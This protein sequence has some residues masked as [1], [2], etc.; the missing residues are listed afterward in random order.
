M[1]DLFEVKRQLVREAEAV[2]CIPEGCMSCVHDPA[3]S[4]RLIL[5]FGLALAIN[6]YDDGLVIQEEHCIS[7]LPDHRRDLLAG[8]HFP[9]VISPHFF[10]QFHLAESSMGG[11][12]DIDAGIH[13]ALQDVQKLAE[14]FCRVGIAF[15]VTSALEAVPA[16]LFAEIIDLHLLCP[17]CGIND[18]STDFSGILPHPVCLILDHLPR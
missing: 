14:L 15:T 16:F 12:H 13:T 3:A 2:L 9:V 17:V 8:L 1:S 6:I 10:R 4:L 7:P 5:P 11:N 18:Q